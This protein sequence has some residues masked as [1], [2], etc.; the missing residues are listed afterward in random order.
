MTLKNMLG[1]KWSYNIRPLSLSLSL[2]LRN[3]KHKMDVKNCFRRT[4]DTFF[5]HHWI[6]TLLHWN[7]APDEFVACTRY[8]FFFF[9]WEAL[10]LTN[11]PLRVRYNTRRATFVTC[12]L[13][14]N[15][16]KIQFA[17]HP[18]A[19]SREP[20]NGRSLSVDRE[21]K[22]SREKK[23][24]DALFLPRR[25]KSRSFATRRRGMPECV[26]PLILSEGNTRSRTIIVSLSL[27][28][29]FFPGGDASEWRRGRFPPLS[30]TVRNYKGESAFKDWERRRS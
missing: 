20:M 3:A 27:S 7:I 21:K 17:K 23:N 25:A 10:Q 30:V 13:R 4:E 9:F 6:F 22:R 26:S 29:S 8:F 2:L 1:W 18:Q 11:G 24:R 14:R 15:G 12:N 19:S 28:L 5:F 16:Q